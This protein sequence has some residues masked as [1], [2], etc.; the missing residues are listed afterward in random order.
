[1]S[2]RDLFVKISMPFPEHALVL[3]MVRLVWIAIC[4]LLDSVD[5]LDTASYTWH[6]PKVTGAIPQPCSHAS[7]VQV[8]ASGAVTPRLIAFGGRVANQSGSNMCHVLETSTWTWVNVQ[9]SSVS[10]PPPPARASHCAVGMGEDMVVFGGSHAGGGGE[11]KGFYTLRVEETVGRLR[12]CG[13]W[14]RHEVVS[15]TSAPSVSGSASASASASASSSTTAVEFSSPRSGACAIGVGGHIY[16]TGGMQTRRN[17]SGGR[18]GSA[19]VQSLY[20]SSVRSKVHLCVPVFVS[21]AVWPF[22]TRHVSTWCDMLARLFFVRCG[23]TV[24]FTLT[25]HLARL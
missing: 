12:L 5:V 18:G 16:F 14:S 6:T 8:G 23:L 3:L 21:C 4:R 24:S 13:T 9:L 7:L 2:A 25:C 19:A 1:M 17:Q 10:G 20:A 22:F 15:H 11:C